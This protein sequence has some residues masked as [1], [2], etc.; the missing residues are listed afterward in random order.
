MYKDS[1]TTEQKCHLDLAAATQSGCRSEITPLPM[2]VGRNGKPNFST[3]SNISFSARAYP[4]PVE[5][6]DRR[7]EELKKFIPEIHLKT[8]F[9]FW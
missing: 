6:S 3:N 7:S 4:A 2:G 8:T 5:V 1:A 9:Q